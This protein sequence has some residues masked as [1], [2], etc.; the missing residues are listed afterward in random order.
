MDMVIV[1][2]TESGTTLSV[3]VSCVVFFIFAKFNFTQVFL[4][5]FFCWG[6]SKWSF[7]KVFSMY[8]VIMITHFRVVITVHFV[9]FLVDCGERKN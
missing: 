4:S 7:L 1:Y 5:S 6:L 8:D 9:E 2:G 3:V